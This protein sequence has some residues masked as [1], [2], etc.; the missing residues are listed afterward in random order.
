[1]KTFAAILIALVGLT[2]VESACTASKQRNTTASGALG[3]TPSPSAPA[4]APTIWPN[5]Y[6]PT[7]YDF[8]REH[9]IPI[10]RRKVLA[11][12]KLLPPAD[13]LYARWL[14]YGRDVV[15]FEVS[16]KQLRSDR[17]YS[18]SPVI[19]MRGFYVDPTS[20]RIFATPQQ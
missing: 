8:D 4:P 5:F 1:M 16:P 13:R 19:G 15:V 10:L 2:L 9:L 7:Q 6:G 20:G 14:P 11:Q 17:R 12:V 3:T 18:P